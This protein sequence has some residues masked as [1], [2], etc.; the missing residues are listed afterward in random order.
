MSELKQTQAI[1][2]SIAAQLADDRHITFQHFVGQDD[3]NAAVNATIDRIMGFID[4]QQKRFKLPKLREEKAQLEGVIAQAEKDLAQVEAEFEAEEQLRGE[5]IGKLQ[6]HRDAVHK[7][8]YAEHTASGRRGAYEAKGHRK[9]EIDR[10][11]AEIGKL[12]EAAVT[13]ANERAVAVQNLNE[14]NAKRKMR[15]AA[16]DAEIAELEAEVS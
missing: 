6:A 2:Y 5:T 12:V 13:R 11:E 1:G 3:D 8:G 16:I 4:R 15:I 9:V 14:N 7:A 10:A